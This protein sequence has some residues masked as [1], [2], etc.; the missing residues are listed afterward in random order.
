MP[1]LGN[2]VAQPP[3]ASRLPRHR[4]RHRHGLQLQL[5]L[6]LSRAAHR[7]GGG[8]GLHRR[9]HTIGA[10][11]QQAPGPA[12]MPRLPLPRGVPRG[13][14][15]RQRR[16]RRRLQVHQPPGRLHLR[17]QALQEADRGQRPG[18]GRLEGGVRPRR[19]RQAQP[20]RPVLLGLGRGRPHA[21]PERVLQRRLTRRAHRDAARHP[22]QP[23]QP[24]QLAHAAAK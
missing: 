6:Q 10:A 12:T 14:Q 8:G 22:L 4:N 24:V 20:H 21:H 1:E 5:Q 16:V 18:G 15:A 3:R 19:P 2:R 7:S 9:A 23:E 13:V 17:H 11:R